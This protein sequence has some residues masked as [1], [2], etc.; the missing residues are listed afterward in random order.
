MMSREGRG[1]RHQISNTTATSINVCRVTAVT[2]PS[3]TPPGNFKISHRRR[4]DERD[5]SRERKLR[6]KLSGTKRTYTVVRGADGTPTSSHA[7]GENVTLLTFGAVSGND[8]DQV[9]NVLKDGTGYHLQGLTGV[10]ACT[11]DHDGRATSI[12]TQSKDYDEISGTSAS[13]QWRDQSVPDADELDDG[14]AVKYDVN[15]EQTLFF[16]ADRFATNGSKDAGFWFFHQKVS[17]VAPV[18][19]ADG[20]FTGVHTAPD[21]GANGIFCG[22]PGQ[23]TP[24]CSP[25]DADDTAGDVLVLTTF[26]QGG[27]V[28]SIRVYEWIGPAGSTAA[29]L[30]RGAAGDCV[31]GDATQQLC[32]TVN[33]TTI[34]SP[35]DYSGKGASSSRRSARAA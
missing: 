35:W 21:P 34:E 11:F 1:P 5:S 26:T 27:A 7:S 13:W 10:T 2:E 22:I 33:D 6:L 29:L 15:G 8:W 25:Y 30:Q 17:P 24:N 16:G 31:P 14:F 3:V 23:T 19:T 28:T 9:Y 18:G 12:F 32:A 20:T 4:A